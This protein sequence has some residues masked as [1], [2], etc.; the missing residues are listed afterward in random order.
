MLLMNVQRSVDHMHMHHLCYQSTTIRVGKK[1]CL[2]S[3]GSMRLDLD[4][5]CNENGLNIYLNPTPCFLVLIIVK[6]S[7]LMT[8]EAQALFDYGTST[9]FMDKKLVWQYKLIL[10]EKHTLLPFEV[11][12]G[13]SLSS[14]PIAHET[15]PLDVTIGSHTN[16]V[17]FNVISSLRNL[18][19]IRLIWLILHN[20]WMDWYMNGAWTSYI[21]SWGCS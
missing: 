17:V 2:I 5:S 20:T 11:I 13:W 12:D 14:W 1:T 15:K 10:V 6:C 9:C 16:K 8:M 3:I 7:K 18:V 4:A 19:I 21:Y